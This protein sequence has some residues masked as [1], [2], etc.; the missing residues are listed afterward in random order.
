MLCG[1]N[2]EKSKSRISKISGKT[3]RSLLCIFSRD[4]PTIFLAG[5]RFFSLKFSVKIVQGRN[6]SRAAVQ[7]RFEIV[8]SRFSKQYKEHLKKKLKI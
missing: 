1:I 3:L 6:H 2:L 4:Y 5:H 7:S 8:Q